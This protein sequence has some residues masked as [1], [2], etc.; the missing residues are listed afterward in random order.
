MGIETARLRLQLYSPRHLLALIDGPQQFE[1]QF[2]LPVA[3]GLRDFM[4]SGDVSPAWLAQLRASHAAPADVWLHGFALVHREDA[5][6]IG[7]AGF[8]GPPG[9]DGVVEIGYG[10]APG[11][12]G[13]GYA[14]EAA[15][16]IVA[17]AFES[18]RVR[19]VRAHTLPT[20]NAST[21]VLAKCGFKR[22]GEVVDPEDGLVWRWERAEE[23][24]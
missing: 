24:V 10:I 23:P 14:T 2:G 8:K 21:R 20:P 17:F 18:G 13:R 16:A 19:Y 9:D 1:E 6:V 3:D 22:L 15:A 7:N 11:Y 12:Q 5:L 4:E